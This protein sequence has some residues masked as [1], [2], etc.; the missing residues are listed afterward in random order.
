MKTTYPLVYGKELE[1]EKDPLA[2]QQKRSTLMI[3]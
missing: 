1:V 2:L 3:D